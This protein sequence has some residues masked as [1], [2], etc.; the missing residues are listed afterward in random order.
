MN[1]ILAMDG[2]TGYLVVAYGVTTL[3]VIGNL[4][5]ARRQFRRVHRRLREQLERR[6]GRRPART[7]SQGDGEVGGKAGNEA[8]VG[9]SS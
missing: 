7:G 3:V 6:S 4:V 9:R 5:A 2:Y 8:T 1:G